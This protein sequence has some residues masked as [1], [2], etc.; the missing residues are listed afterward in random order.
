MRQQSSRA[1]YHSEFSDLRVMHRASCIHAPPTSTADSYTTAQTSEGACSRVRLRVVSCRCITVTSL[2]KNS[3]RSLGDL[4]EGRCPLR[5]DSTRITNARNLG[6]KDI[7]NHEYLNIAGL[8][9]GRTWTRCIHCK[10]YCKHLALQKKVLAVSIL[11]TASNFVI[12]LQI[13]N[14]RPTVN[15]IENMSL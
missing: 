7:L 9:Y 2:N 3:G 12:D 4:Y 13:C 5:K 8:P 14:R 10:R 15:I 1:G 11:F 6:N